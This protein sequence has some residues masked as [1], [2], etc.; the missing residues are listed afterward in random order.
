[1]TLEVLFSTVVLHMITTVKKTLF[2]QPG[3]TI[4]LRENRVIIKQ[5]K[6]IN[7]IN[8]ISDETGS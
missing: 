2:I 3:F 8:G 4:A 7:K 1:M 6:S 5:R